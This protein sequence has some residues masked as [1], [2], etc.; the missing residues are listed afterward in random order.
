[1]ICDTLL[2][3]LSQSEDDIKLIKFKLIKYVCVQFITV[4]IFKVAIKFQ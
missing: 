3:I 2:N 1:M 4:Y